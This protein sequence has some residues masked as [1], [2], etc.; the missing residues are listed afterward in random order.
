M[1]SA[2]PKSAESRCFND[3]DA[4]HGLNPAVFSKFPLDTSHIP[5]DVRPD[6]FIEPARVGLTVAVMAHKH[7][8]RQLWASM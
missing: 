2:F 4:V 6:P 3:Q 8:L 1:A 5:V 7:P